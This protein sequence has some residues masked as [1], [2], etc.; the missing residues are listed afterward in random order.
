[1]PVNLKDNLREYYRMASW[2]RPGILGTEASFNSLFMQPIEDG[3]ARDAE[4][5]AVAMQVTK[6]K[7]LH[8]I[9]E[10]FTQRRDNTI[11]KKELPP[12]QE[13]IL[14]V[15]Q[16][17]LQRSLYAAFK[18][19]SIKHDS[20]N[21]FRLYKAQF[22]VNNHPGT[23][24]IPPRHIP[25]PN[26]KGGPKSLVVPLASRFLADSNGLGTSNGALI[27]SQKSPFIVRDIIELLSDSDDDEDDDQEGKADATN[28]KE[29]SPYIPR[30]KLESEGMILNT[31]AES[32]V[33][34]EITDEL[35]WR[36][37]LAKRGEH[38]F[39]KVEQG[40]KIVFLLHILAY[41]Q[42]I[43]DKV[44]I[45]S[46]SLP[47]LDFLEN[48][49]S[50]DWSVYVNEGNK[51]SPSI[52]L[53]GWKKQLDYYRIDGGTSASDRGSFITS[54]NNGSESKAFLISIQAGG[55]G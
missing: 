21:F 54:F 42:D 14:H 36:P 18:R 40:K 44:V 19:H 7:E 24:L 6:S 48:I 27:R 1:M 28:E 30:I 53:G 25:R 23:L 46:Q 32:S 34:P 15:R 43:G 31:G 41:S 26:N 38:E 35:W 51:L 10:N 16:S 17:P 29:L 20:T 2:V 37:V 39:K 8:Q 12:L 52:K 5:E 3:M 50:R 11:L 49:L 55:I 45:F 4:A 33:V 13:S 47:T 9:M 22:L